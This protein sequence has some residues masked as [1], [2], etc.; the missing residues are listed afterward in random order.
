ML[1]SES[2]SRPPRVTRITATRATMLIIKYYV[3]GSVLSRY[4]CF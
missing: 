3:E 4:L 2:S 1:A